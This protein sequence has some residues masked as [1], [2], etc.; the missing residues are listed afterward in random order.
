MNWRPT[1]RWAALLLVLALAGIA[2]YVLG[3]LRAWMPN[4][5]VGAVTVAFTVTLID[6][7]IRSEVELQNK[8]RLDDAL[9]AISF[10]FRGLFFGVAFDYGQTHTHVQELPR[11]P[12]A[13]L[14]FW[15][16][17]D[18]SRDRDRHLTVGASFTM[19][20]DE[21]ARLSETLSKHIGLNRDVF[22][23]DLLLA[24]DRFIDAEKNA[25]PVGGFVQLGEVADPQ[26]ALADA[27]EQLVQAARGLA[28]EYVELRPNWSPIDELTKA[29]A[30]VGNSSQA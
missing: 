30:E 28:V 6:R 16:A 12:L 19:L 10:P 14:D 26:A 8:P 17:Q 5:V 9:D 20:T 29:A 23:T 21:A 1:S 3:W 11:D 25:A 13:L 2:V 24:T 4:V 22:T 18:P 27:H 15:L 7:A